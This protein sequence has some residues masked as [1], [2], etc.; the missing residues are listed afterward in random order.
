MA[1]TPY[2]FNETF[3]GEACT[4]TDKHEV[5]AEKKNHMHL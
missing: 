5:T 2:Y 3:S 1:L 4:I